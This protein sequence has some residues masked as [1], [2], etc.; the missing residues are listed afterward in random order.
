MNFRA[1]SIQ[2][3]AVVGSDYGSMP[4]TAQGLLGDN[5]VVGIADTGLD[6]NSCYFY[7]SQGRVQPKD[8]SQPYY[9]NKYRKVIQYLYNGCGDT[10]DE[11]GG[12]GT[13]VSG[14]VAGNIAGKDIT[15]GKCPCSHKTVIVLNTCY[16]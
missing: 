14:I 3:I 4:Y 6:V 9:D 8:I 7:D 15:S 11:E 13:H 12:H 10:S 5:Q 2:Q 16:L 1:R